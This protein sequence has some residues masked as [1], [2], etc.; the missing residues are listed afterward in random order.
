[1]LPTKFQVNWPFGSEEE[2][3]NRFSRWAPWRPAWISDRNDFSYFLINM[4]PRCFLP[5]FKSI[6]LLVQE[7]KR[8]IY[9][10]DGCHGGHLGFTI[11][12]ILAIFDLQVPLMLSTKFQVN[13]PFGSGK[14]AEN[15]FSSWPSWRPSR[16]S[17]WND[18]S[19]F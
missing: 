13:W 8:K 1:M 2:A 5:N 3:K 11:G 4:S 9:L 15:R 12:T 10:Q 16:I 14:E 7:K 6:G 19:Y 18:F 17:D